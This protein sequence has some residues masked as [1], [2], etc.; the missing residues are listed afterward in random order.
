[1]AAPTSTRRRQVSLQLALVTNCVI[2]LLAPLMLRST[3]L[4][5]TQKGCHSLTVKAGNR[6]TNLAAA[7][8]RADNWPPTCGRRN[9]AT[10]PSGQ[11]GSQSLCPRHRRRRQLSRWCGRKQALGR[12]RRAP[13]SGEHSSRATAPSNNSNRTTT[14]APKRPHER[15]TLRHVA[16]RQIRSAAAP[17]AA[18][19]RQATG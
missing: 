18:R 19:H 8:K 7:L 16:K 14:P 5:C 10:W 6:D 4:Q 12:R 1:M 3:S 2:S 13:S 15:A 11:L 17:V 9:L